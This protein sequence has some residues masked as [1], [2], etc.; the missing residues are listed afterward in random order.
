MRHLAAIPGDAV[1]ATAA[2]AAGQALSL[3]EL[4]S[5]ALVH[6]QPSKDY[7]DS[8]RGLNGCVVGDDD[9]NDDE[10]DDDDED[11]DDNE[12]DVDDKDMEAEYHVHPEYHD[13]AD[14]KA[15]ARAMLRAAILVNH[16]WFAA[17]V[18]V[19][20]WF[21]SEDAL[22]ANAVHEPSRRAYYAAHVR[23]VVLSKRGAMWRALFSAD[24]G[25]NDAADTTV[26]LVILLAKATA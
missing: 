4:I 22:H 24:S 16:M 2:S 17:G 19:L 12:D 21:P 11:Y 14:E 1:A 6:V 20:W 15:A 9:D 23:R 10:D 18:P 26:R 7:T 5:A 8:R 13:T 25:Q 3:P